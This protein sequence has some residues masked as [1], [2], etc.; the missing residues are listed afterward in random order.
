MVLQRCHIEAAAV[1]IDTVVEL[2]VVELK[3]IA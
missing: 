3:V 2:T 1:G